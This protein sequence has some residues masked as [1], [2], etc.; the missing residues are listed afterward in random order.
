MSKAASSPKPAAAAPAKPAAAD[1]KA[2][3]DEKGDRL[4]LAGNSSVQKMLSKLGNN[5]PSAE[6]VS[7]SDFVIKINKREK[8]Q[9]RVMLITDKAM[10]VASLTTTLTTTTPLHFH[11]NAD[12]SPSSSLVVSSSSPGSR[13][14]SVTI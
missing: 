5:K 4:S 14:C 8:E 9:T 2:A 6:V 10:S 13:V 7:F 11:D 1:K 3:V 12:V